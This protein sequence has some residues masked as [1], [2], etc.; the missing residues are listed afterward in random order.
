MNT[1]FERVN[2]NHRV[3]FI[4]VACNCWLGLR[5]EFTGSF[6]ILAA[7]LLAVLNYGK[8]SYTGIAALSISYA[9]SIT[10]V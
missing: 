7:T 9:L 4:S 6:V 2:N 8:S 3:Y 5:L 1:N 10:S